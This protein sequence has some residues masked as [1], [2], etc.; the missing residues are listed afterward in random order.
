M[1][2][3]EV[4]D[5]I[6][7]Y[8][9]TGHSV[10]LDKFIES[11]YLTDDVAG[12]ILGFI[13]WS[14]FAWIVI[15]T[16]MDIIYITIPIIRSAYDEVRDKYDLDNRVFKVGLISQDA[17]RSVKDAHA[18][19]SLP[20]FLYLRKRIKTIIFS[21]FLFVV[22]IASPNLVI[23]VVSSVLNGVFGV[24]QKLINRIV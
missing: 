6:Q 15:I 23:Q 18:T 11:K 8:I 7:D 12:F 2:P 1:N 19:N 9:G 10:A 16:C 3:S 5:S 22:L 24:V 20:M 13:G 14:M 21:A 4:V 17:I